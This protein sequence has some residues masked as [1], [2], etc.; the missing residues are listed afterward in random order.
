M[1]LDILICTCLFICG[2]NFKNCFRWF[3]KGEKTLLN[4][5]FLW[6]L[7]FGCAYVFFNLSGNG[8][9]A[10]IY[11]LFPKVNSFDNVIKKIIEGSPSGYI[12]VINYFPSH[13]LSL[14]FFTVSMFYTLVG[15][16]GFVFLL[17][18]VK[19]NIP[20][21]NVLR[22]VKLF[23][24]PIFPYMLFLPNLHFW[25]AGLGKDTLL[26]LSIT[27]FIYA[28][29][30]LKGRLLFMAISISISIFI[31]PHI[32]LF[33][34][35]SVG[36]SIFFY[37]K[38]KL[39]WKILLSILF[40]IVLVILIPRVMAF[41]K[42]ESLQASSFEKFANTKAKKLNSS[43]TGSG[44]DISSYSYPYKVFTFLFRPLFFDLNGVL[45]LFA[46]IEN[47][48]LMFFS[49][50]VVRRNIVKGFSMGNI[51]IKTIFLFFA[52]GSLVFPLILGNLGI[53]LRQKTPF[54]ILFIVFGFWI[55][56]LPN[57]ASRNALKLR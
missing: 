40:V 14:S 27:L 37:N 38:V 21:Y 3:S 15:Y 57:Q 48:I 45:A 42:I 53:I 1:V 18:I 41:T 4:Y 17:V 47:L 10:I 31:R 46:S 16:F 19:E 26:F 25:T 29:N 34:C 33:L 6:H 49:L 32:L 55:L 8:G 44:I 13:V 51:T 23:G 12:Y 22:K 39:Y 54:I 30:K 52:I 24:L 43:G 28:L 7:F 35:M 9:D 36:L 2:I 11:W 56:A 50:M 5:L 20:N